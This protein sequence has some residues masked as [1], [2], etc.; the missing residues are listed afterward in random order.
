[1]AEQTL[2]IPAAEF[3]HAEEMGYSKLRINKAGGKAINI[4]NKS[5]NRQLHLTCGLMLTW[6]VNKRVDEQSGRVSF[7]MALQFP[8]EEY[9]TDQTDKFLENIT[10]IEKDLIIKVD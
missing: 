6:G 3:N 7:D 8:K 1:M 4:V 10:I 5:N 2:M 9:S